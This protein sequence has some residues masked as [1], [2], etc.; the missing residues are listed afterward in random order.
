M[1]KAKCASMVQM[2]TF[3]QAD[4]EKEALFLKELPPDLHDLYKEATPNLWIAVEKMPHFYTCGAR[5]L[6]PDEQEPII[7]LGQAV[8][9]KIYSGLYAFFLRVPTVEFVLKR[10]TNLWYLFHDSG[11]FGYEHLTKTSIDLYARDYPELAEPIRKMI[12]G[13]IV[14]LLKLIRLKPNVPQLINDDPNNWRW[15]I[16]LEEQ[17]KRKNK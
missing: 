16:E 8:G 17:N 4:P 15:H 5:A 1:P 10:S 11:R 6:F 2:R 13:N 3:L 12:S 9:E 14:T 7:K